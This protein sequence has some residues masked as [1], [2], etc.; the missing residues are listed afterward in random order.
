MRAPLRPVC[1]LG[2]VVAA[3]SWDAVEPAPWCPPSALAAVG[4]QE[5]GVGQ[6]LGQGPVVVDGWGMV[7]GLGL[8]APSPLV[9][10]GSQPLF[11]IVEK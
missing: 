3:A 8:P 5:R 2:L 4:V 1:L 10:R 6:G 9:Q 11:A 7:V